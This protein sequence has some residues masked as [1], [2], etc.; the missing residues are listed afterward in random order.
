MPDRNRRFLLRE[1]PSG[2]L[3]PNTFE[4][5]DEAVPEISDGEALVRV[6]KLVVKT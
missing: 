4:L 3:G 5:S 2:L 1:R 6:G